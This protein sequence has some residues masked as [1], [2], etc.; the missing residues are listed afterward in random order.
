MSTPRLAKDML[1]GFVERIE[2][3][4]SEVKELNSDKS[5]IYGEAKSSGFDPKAIK[6][7]VAYRRKDPNEAQELQALFETHLAALGS[8]EGEINAPAAK[9]VAARGIVANP[10]RVHAH[11]ATPSPTAVGVEPSRPVASPLPGGAVPEHEDIP[12]FLDRRKLVA[13]A[14]A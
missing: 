9:S 4:E 14:G 2:R 3:V 8:G 10:S 13:G 1:K 12:T 5:D 11:E 7:V 6:A